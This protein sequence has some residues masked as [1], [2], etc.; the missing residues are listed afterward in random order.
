MRR[1]ADRYFLSKRNRGEEQ[2]SIYLRDSF[3]RED[4]RLLDPESLGEGK[5]ASVTIVDISEDGSLLAYGVRTG[6]QGA[7]RVRILDVTTGTTLPDE[8][9][10]GALRGF[11]FLK[12]GK[13]VVYVTEKFGKPTQA[14][15]VK[16]HPIGT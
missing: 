10:K 2:S 4:R 11:S 7:R 16:V 13:G 8:L 5:D 6:G 15:T 3:D 14:K 9:P 1:V 12:N